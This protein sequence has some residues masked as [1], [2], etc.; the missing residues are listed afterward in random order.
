MAYLYT[1]Q[2]LC[3]NFKFSVSGVALAHQWSLSVCMHCLVDREI[4]ALRWVLEFGDTFRGNLTDLVNTVHPRKIR[5]HLIARLDWA[6][7]GS[8]ASR[9][10]YNIGHGYKVVSTSGADMSRICRMS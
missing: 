1:A 3:F 4:T 10:Y 8:S 6:V 7:R 2:T 9:L 5:T